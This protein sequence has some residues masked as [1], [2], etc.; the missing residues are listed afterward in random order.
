[1]TRNSTYEKNIQPGR[2]NIQSTCKKNSTC[3]HRYHSARYRKLHVQL[4]LIRFGS[5]LLL[6]FKGG[7]GGGNGESG[8]VKYYW[9]ARVVTVFIKLYSEK[10]IK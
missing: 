7:G 6:A 4:I 3:I 2:K 8:K 1:M 10:K 9:T 5:P